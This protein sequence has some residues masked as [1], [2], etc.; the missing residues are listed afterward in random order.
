MQK[1]RKGGQS[2]YIS[3]V[4]FSLKSPP[5]RPFQRKEPQRNAAIGPRV[6]KPD[7]DTAR[8]QS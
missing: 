3:M 6:L 7:F 8:N 1:D 5:R 4:E 2:S